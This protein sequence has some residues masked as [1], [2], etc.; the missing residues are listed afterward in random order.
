MSLQILINQPE[1]Q[2]GMAGPGGICTRLLHCQPLEMHMFGLAGRLHDSQTAE[3]TRDTVLQLHTVLR[4]DKRLPC[5]SCLECK[6]SVFSP[7]LFECHKTQPCGAAHS[8]RPHLPINAFQAV[9]RPDC[10]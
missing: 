5:P 2:E 6:P 7:V 4:S 9:L 1:L 10:C 8:V 3:Y